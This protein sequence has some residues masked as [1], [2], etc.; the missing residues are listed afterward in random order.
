MKR[1]K[2]IIIIK[3]FKMKVFKLDET[4]VVIVRSIIAFFTL[5]LFSR[6]LGKQQ[7]S[8]LTFFEYVLGITIGSIAATLSV[9]LT[10]RAWPHWVGLLTWTITVVI[11]QYASLKSSVAKKF[12][13]GRPTIVIE[14]GVIKEEEMK[15]LRYTLTDLLE[16]LRNKGIFDLSQVAFAILET[17][18]ELSVLLKSEYQTVTRQ[19]LEIAAPESTL[20]PQIIFNGKIVE[21]NLAYL[22]KDQAWLI[23]ELKGHGI[24]DPREVF[25]AAYNT[26][27]QTL[28]IDKYK[29][30]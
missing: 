15:K 19:D 14:N 22:N 23:N 26:A 21:Q 17:N 30:Q 12:L 16:Q 24:N 2:F 27:T 4:I 11:L 3:T 18:G 9:D 1:E 8:Q 7:I 5:F 20:S 6:L 25:V 29:D 10:S 13:V 28:Y